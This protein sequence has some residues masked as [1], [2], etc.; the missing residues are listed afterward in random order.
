MRNSGLTSKADVL[1]TGAF[2][3]LRLRKREALQRIA[4]FIR[5]NYFLGLFAP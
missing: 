5:L 3:V 1:G 4:A 2:C